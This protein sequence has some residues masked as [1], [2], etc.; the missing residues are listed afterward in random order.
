MALPFIL[1]VFVFS[2]IPLFGWIYAFFDYKPGIPLS[3]TAFVGFKFFSIAF[4]GVSGFLGSLLNSLAISMLGIL[5]TPLPVVL[6]ILL[7]EVKSSKFKRFVQTTTTLPNFISWVIVFSLA[8]NIFSTNGVLNNLL[9]KL[10]LIG[11]DSH[12]EILGNEAIAW[13]FQAALLMW[14][15][16][17]W[18]AI[19]YIAAIA[20]IDTGLYDAAHVDGAGRWGIIRNVTI[21]G[22]MSTFIVLLLLN[23]SNAVNNGLDQFLVF[24]NPLVANK[25]EVLDYFVY[26]IGIKGN[27]YALATAIGIFKTALSLVLLSVANIISKKSRG[28]YIV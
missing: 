18:N 21:P 10:H 26:R 20:G 5:V 1:L 13:Y 28:E 2:Y 24:Y 8:F 23:I 22:I 4:T 14:K 27:D 9:I 25:I 3:H 7:N 19:I 17:G 12:V 16:I 6:A 15:T 11:T